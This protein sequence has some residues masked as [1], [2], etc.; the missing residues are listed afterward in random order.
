MLVANPSASCVCVCVRISSRLD[1]ACYRCEPSVHSAQLSVGFSVSFGIRLSSQLCLYSNLLVYLAPVQAASAAVAAAAS[2]P[3][4][5]AAAVNWPMAFCLQN[6]SETLPGLFPFGISVSV[7]LCVLL[8][9]GR[10]FIIV[11]PL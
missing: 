2:P 9:F 8:S 4:A 11:V 3:P 10:L 5:A 7:V 1:D 6:I